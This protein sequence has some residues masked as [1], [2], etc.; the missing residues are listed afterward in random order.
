MLSWLDPR[1]QDRL[2]AELRSYKAEPLERN[3]V[4]EWNGPSLFP[5]ST[6][7]LAS[8]A[9]ARRTVVSSVLTAS[10]P[11]HSSSVGWSLKLVEPLKVGE[12]SNRNNNQV[13][14]C[15]IGAPA[16]ESEKCIVI[17]LYYDGVFFHRDGKMGPP[18]QKYY[19]DGEG[20]AENEAL[21]CVP[22]LP[23]HYLLLLR[24]TVVLSS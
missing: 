9:S 3:D 7:E 16:G 6:V 13:W 14:R 12:F 1:K 5:Q 18:G 23:W 10:G 8:T 11:S 2:K 15:Q 24:L 19:M 4:L 22:P 21:A 17:K 20:L